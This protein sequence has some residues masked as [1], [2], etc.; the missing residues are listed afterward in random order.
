MFSVT[1]SAGWQDPHQ[2]AALSSF[3]WTVYETTRKEGPMSEHGEVV[4]PLQESEGG[5]NRLNMDTGSDSS[6]GVPPSSKFQNSETDSHIPFSENSNPLHN[7]SNA[8]N[9]VP[10]FSA[11]EDATEHFGAEQPSFQND[12]ELDPSASFPGLNQLTGLVPTVSQLTSMV[13]TNATDALVT[14]MVT[15]P[16][17]FTNFHCHPKFSKFQTS[18]L[19]ARSQGAAATPGGSYSS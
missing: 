4:S 5:P 3:L 17:D 10:T 18:A 12:T 15:I 9:A 6:H 7:S 13:P 16:S 11:R 19:D 2:L 8:Y 14:V 1:E